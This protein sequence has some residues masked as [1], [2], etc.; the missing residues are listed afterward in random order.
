MSA[1]YIAGPMTGL[2]E[3]NYPAFNATSVDLA[4]AGYD[5][6]NPVDIEKG[7]PTPGSPQAWE[8][9]MHRA[10]A[11]VV[12]ADGIALLPGWHGSRGARREVQIALAMDLPIDTVGGWLRLSERAA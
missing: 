5:V 2:P 6:L 3:F 10:H 12:Q 8:W 9:Y 11:M 1:L 4:A 7:N